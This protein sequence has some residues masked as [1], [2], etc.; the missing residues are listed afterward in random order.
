M[1]AQVFYSRPNDFN[2]SVEVSGVFCEFQGR[3]LFLKRH[4]E[5]IEG[6][7][8]GVPGGKLEK[9]E[10]PIDG[11]I[12]EL[13]E[14]AG[15]QSSKETLAPIDALFIRRPEVD[16]I[17]YMFYL[18]LHEMPM[19]N[20]AADENTEACWTNLQEGLK[21][22]LISGGKEALEFFYLWKNDRKIY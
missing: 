6:L 15:I 11:A 19:L 9:G 22:L 13:A 1:K 20:I 18:P 14:E 21:L 3:I 5:K 17:F 10:T 16:F 2:P 7:C 12:R 4:A 8:W